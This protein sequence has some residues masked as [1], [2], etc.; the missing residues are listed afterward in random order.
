MNDLIERYIYAVTRRLPRSK[1][2]DVARELRGLVEDMLQER[3]GEAMPEEKDVRIVLTELGSPQELYEKYDENSGKCL[4]GQPYYTSY[5]FVLKIALLAVSVGLTISAGI[6]CLLEHG[7]V[8][9]GVLSWLS[10]LYNGLLSA[11]AIVTLLFAF[12]Y[13]KHIPLSQPFNFD[14]L[15]PVPKKNERIPKWECILGICLLVVLP[16]VFLAVPQ[17]LGVYLAEE[18]RL[19]PMFDPAAVR[20]TWYFLGLFTLCGIIRECVRLQEGRYNWRVLVT[21]VVSN[22]ASAVFAIWWLGGFNL[23]NPE[24]TMRIHTLYDGE[25][26]IVTRI[27]AHFQSFVLV[28]ILFALAVDTVEAAVKTRKAVK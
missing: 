11:F 17:S 28:C 22:V 14:D 25:A 15:P 16:V 3:C 21:T 7:S 12:F 6:T 2:E 26:E 1:Q 24:F 23:M 27:F 10:M 4:I 8:F 18:G 13:K 9:D 20:E 19:I 5:L